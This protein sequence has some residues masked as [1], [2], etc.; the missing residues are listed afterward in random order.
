MTKLLT[1]FR[2]TFYQVGINMKP[3]GLTRHQWNLWFNIGWGYSYRDRG[4]HDG[5]PL[6]S[7]SGVQG[8]ELWARVEQG[9]SEETMK[10]ESM[11]LP[12]MKPQQQQW[13][14]LM[15][16]TLEAAIRRQLR[17]R[18]E[19]TSGEH[20]MDRKAARR[21]Q[22]DGSGPPGLTAPRHPA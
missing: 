7:G 8:L 11:K 20:T 19:R 4:L 14:Q 9:G 18:L 15:R 6:S 2:S 3:I 21:A 22:M 10:E 16:F 1:N 12:E 13:Q 17:L 5:C